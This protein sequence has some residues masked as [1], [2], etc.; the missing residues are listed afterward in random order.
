MHSL[1]RISESRSSKFCLQK[2]KSK[3]A[4]FYEALFFNGCQTAKYKNSLIKKHWKNKKLDF[5]ILNETNIQSMCSLGFFSELPNFLDRPAPK[6]SV[7]AFFL[8]L[9][10]LIVMHIDDTP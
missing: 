10:S 2:S 6:W 8:D 7:L 5:F 1:S 3:D 9:S 4:K